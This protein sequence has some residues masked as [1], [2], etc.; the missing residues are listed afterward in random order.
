MQKRSFKNVDHLNTIIVKLGKSFGGGCLGP[1]PSLCEIV[2]YNSKIK[3]RIYY[4]KENNCWPSERRDSFS[5]V[6][7]FFFFAIVN[8]ISCLRISNLRRSPSPEKDGISK[9]L[10][11]LYS[12]FIEE[13]KSSWHLLSFLVNYS[14]DVSCDK[15]TC[16]LQ[17]AR[18]ITA[19]DPPRFVGAW[20]KCCSMGRLQKSSFIYEVHAI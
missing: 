18:N 7:L 15:A 9:I 4:K 16:N 3:I 20:D 1:N 5:L 11:V 17:T 10:F 14:N 19:V 12:F 8:V 13:S 2:P 6:L